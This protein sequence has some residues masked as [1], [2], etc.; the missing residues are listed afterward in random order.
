MRYIYLHGFASGPGSSKARFFAAKFAELERN[1][2]VPDLAEGDFERLTI[3]RMLDVIDSVRE[4]KRCA[5]L[6]SSLGG[7][8]AALYAFRNPSAVDRLVLMAP[9]F[10][11]PSRWPQ[12]IGPE[13][14]AEWR[15]KGRLEFFHYG[16]GR[17]LPLGWSFMEDAAKY[18]DVP[19]FGQPGLIFHGTRDDVVPDAVSRSFAADHRNAELRL[20]DSGHELN[21]VTGVMWQHVRRFLTLG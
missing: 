5:L 13:R 2:L 14:M 15:A 10:E 1:L 6:G 16:A 8:L 7:Y 18:P 9:G 21:D 4:A 11:F 19:N 3:T 17:Q 12:Y 20:L